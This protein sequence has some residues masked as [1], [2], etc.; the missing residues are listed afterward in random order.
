MR[1]FLSVLYRIGTHRNRLCCAAGM[2]ALAVMF[3]SQGAVH[4][5]MVAIDS[6][7][8][9]S[10][11]FFI[12]GAG[13]NPSE[14]YSQTTTAAIGGQRDM[15]VNVHG[16]AYANSVEGLVG[17]DQDFNMNA[18]QIGTN[19]TAGAKVTLNYSADN[20][21]GTDGESH[22]A[23][24]NSAFDLTGGG[25][26][27]RFLIQFVGSDARPTV[28]LGITVTITSPGGLQSVGTALA[29]NMLSPFNLYIKFS[30]LVGNASP[31]NVSGI[32][33]TFNANQTPNVDFEVQMLGTTGPAVPEPTS[34]ALA[35]TGAGTLAAVAIARRR[36]TAAARSS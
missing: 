29:P 33:F 13:M 21:S 7:N 36:R 31:A 11:E 17:Y 34:I 27:D 14:S 22:P 9:P 35:M 3:C 25:T 12:V 23:I 19:G 5:G 20:D 16:Q 15:T 4:A 26:D 6:F 32:A 1:E 24:S 8:D 2:A 18:M 28:G 10:P 30:D